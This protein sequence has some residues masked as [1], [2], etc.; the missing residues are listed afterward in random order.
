MLWFIPCYTSS[1][2]TWFCLFFSTSGACI[3]TCI[4]FFG[5]LAQKKIMFCST[6][7]IQ[8]FRYSCFIIN[9]YFQIIVCGKIW[10]GF[11]LF[12]PSPL[13]CMAHVV[14]ITTSQI[15]ILH[16]MWETTF[17][18]FRFLIPN[19]W[20]NYNSRMITK[21]TYLAYKSGVGTKRPYSLT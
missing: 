12:L 16:P 6:K 1:L 17:T 19:S 11:L 5:K 13:L 4:L 3:F 15:T 2:H 18:T 8:L 10:F 7:L 20:T 9:K 14:V 21:T